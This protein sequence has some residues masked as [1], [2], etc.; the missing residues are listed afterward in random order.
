MISTTAAASIFLVK[1]K[2]ISKKFLS[3]IYF[4]FFFVYIKLCN[5]ICLLKKSQTMCLLFIF[6][7]SYCCIQ[8]F[9]SLN[10]ENRLKIAYHFTNFANNFRCIFPY[11]ISLRNEHSLYGFYFFFFNLYT[12]LLYLFI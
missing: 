10:L 2:H 12:Q 3:F 4:Y 11:V 1:K 7:S 8:P 6:I 9:S 5:F